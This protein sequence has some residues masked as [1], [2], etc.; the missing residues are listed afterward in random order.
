[1]SVVRLF[2]FFF[3]WLYLE[4]FPNNFWLNLQ[5]STGIEVFVILNRAY[6]SIFSKIL[7]FSLVHS[8]ILFFLAFP[9]Y[10]CFN[11]SLST[12]SCKLYS[13]SAVNYVTETFLFG[14]PLNFIF[15]SLLKV[16]PC[17]PFTGMFESIE[18]KQFTSFSSF[19]FVF[20]L[21]LLYK[22][23]AI[24]GIFNASWFYFEPLIFLLPF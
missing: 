16:F 1:M 15:L 17:L 3:D 24:Q 4:Y 14:W 22:M 7:F 10:F 12:L 6:F 13:P 8:I 23:G 21:L 11:L 5:I 20:L 2:L 9:F 19:L 18:L